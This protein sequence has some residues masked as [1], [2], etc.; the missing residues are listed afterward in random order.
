MATERFRLPKVCLLRKNV[1]FNRV[2]SLGNRLHGKGFSLIFTP[3]T[4]EFNRL[5]ISVT[6]KTGK[7]VDRNRIK[8]IIREAFRLYRDSFPA[9]SDIIVTVRPGFSLRSPFEVLAAVGG[10]LRETRQAG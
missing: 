6:K 9:K 7:A 3:N 8:R 10:L 5:G 2:Y 4:L 1:E